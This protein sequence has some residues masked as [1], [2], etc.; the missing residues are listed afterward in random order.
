MPPTALLL[1]EIGNRLVLCLGDVNHATRALQGDRGEKKKPSVLDRG[2]GAGASGVDE[3]FHQHQEGLHRER[4]FCRVS[5]ILA[6]KIL[7]ILQC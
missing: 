2:Q 3:L 1:N 4:V 5:V 7:S 6:V